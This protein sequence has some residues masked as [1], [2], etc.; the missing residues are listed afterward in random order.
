MKLREGFCLGI[1]T[2]RIVGRMWGKGKM[3]SDEFMGFGV[4]LGQVCIVTILMA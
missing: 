3:S 1:K 4:S 2:N